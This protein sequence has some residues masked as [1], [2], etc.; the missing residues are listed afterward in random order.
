MNQL[1]HSIVE[2]TRWMSRDLM[3]DRSAEPVL[4]NQQVVRTHNYGFGNLREARP[5]VVPNIVSSK[6]SE[7][8]VRRADAL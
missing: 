5:Y 4:A 1:S 7:E 6:I 8:L 3:C 2:T